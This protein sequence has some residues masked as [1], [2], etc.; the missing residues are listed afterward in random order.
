VRAID[1]ERWKR[2][3]PL[4][5]RALEMSAEERIPWLA[6]ACADDPTVAE[7]VMRLLAADAIAARDGFLARRPFIQSPVT[8]PA[9]APNDASGEQSVDP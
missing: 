7:D 4:L 1:R 9:R 8:D 5:D 3:E 6:L 2:L